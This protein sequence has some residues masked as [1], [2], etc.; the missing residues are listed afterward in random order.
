MATID[1][2]VLVVAQDVDNNSSKKWM[3][4]LSDSGAT[5]AVLID[6]NIG[7]ALGF[8]DIADADIN[9]AEKPQ[10]LEMRKVNAT[11]L[12]G[13]IKIQYPVGKPSEDIY[14]EG[15]TITV[16]RKGSADGLI[17]TVTGVVGEKRRLPSSRDSGQDSGDAS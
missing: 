14:S 17:L 6:E 8:D 11:S 10:S 12:N 5:F 1:I 4:Y 9:F 2:N 13:K 16:P 7:E 3:K 15:G